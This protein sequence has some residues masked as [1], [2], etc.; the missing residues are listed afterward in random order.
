MTYK[1]VLTAEETQVAIKFIKDK[2]QHNLARRLNLKRVTA[3]VFVRA[4]SGLND[5]L[6]GVERKVS[7][8]A[9][10]IS[11]QLEVVQSL[12]K[13]KRVALAKYKFRL[14]EGLYTD[15]NA[16]RPDEKPDRTHS[17]FVDQWDW[18]KVIDVKDRN[19][20]YLKKTVKSIVAALD[21]TAKQVAKAFPTV[22][23]SVTKDV[24]FVT[25][26][27]LEDMYPSLTPAQREQE[28]TRQH[29]TVFVMQ[30]GGLLKSGAKH[31]D[32]APDY[33]DWKLNGDLL[34]WNDVL[35]E[36]MELSS[37]GIRVDADSLVYQLIAKGCDEKLKLPYHSDLV[38]GKLPYTIG[39]GIGQSRLC[40]F[41]L[42]KRH[43][44]EVQVSVWPDDQLELCAEE[45]ITLL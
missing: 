27:E 34:V 17:V 30:I 21:Q 10:G 11:G 2:F 43:I 18:E 42:K 5:D 22:D 13:W 31:D 7:F 26:Q 9:R 33:D 24:Y 4:D 3:P 37:M 44:G 1:S 12:A 35:G 36:A 28:I 15:M 8:T 23:I 19:T 14:G 20:D 45:N 29:K 16:M 38:S 40:M 25:S 32:R 41:L 6:N 39:G